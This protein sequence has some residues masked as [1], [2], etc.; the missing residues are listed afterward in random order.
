M[1]I[2]ID[3]DSPHKFYYDILRIISILSPKGKGVTDS[4]AQVL[5]SFMALGKEH[6][7]YPFSTK[8][9]KHVLSKTS[10]S[11]QALYNRFASLLR[12][13]ILIRDEDNLIDF[14]PAIKRLLKEPSVNVSIQYR[15][16]SGENSKGSGSPTTTS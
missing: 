7:Y 2:N 3:S 12:K 10:L 8:A 16:P 15:P 6:S 11:R 4:E 5:A 13:K 14:N 1:I 9:R